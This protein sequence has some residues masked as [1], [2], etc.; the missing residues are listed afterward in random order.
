MILGNKCDMNDKRQV[1]KERGE[2]VWAVYFC[3]WQ[4]WLFFYPSKTFI[5]FQLA[6]DYCIKFLE[7]SAKSGINVEEVTLLLIHTITNSAFCKTIGITWNKN[8]KRFTVAACWYILTFIFL[9][10]PFILSLGTS[11]RDWTGE[12]W[13]HSETSHRNAYIHC[14]ERSRAVWQV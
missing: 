1:S 13:V 2:K 5:F 12:W 3:F 8:Y 14:I 11:W 4:S 9:H 10:R 6:I 7:T